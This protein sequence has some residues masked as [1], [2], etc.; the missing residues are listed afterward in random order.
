MILSHLH[1]AVNFGP[2]LSSMIS[3]INQLIADVDSAEGVT[4]GYTVST[5]DF[6]A[7]PTY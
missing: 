6:S 7:Y 3:E 4:T 5:A 2:N 1:T